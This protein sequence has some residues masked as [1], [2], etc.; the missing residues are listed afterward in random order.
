MADA[1]SGGTF[2]TE[3][4][5]ESRSFCLV[6]VLLLPLATLGSKAVFQGPS[7]AHHAAEFSPNAI[8][9]A[10]TS[11][12]GSRTPSA[13]IACEAPEFLRPP[14]IYNA[15]PEEGAALPTGCSVRVHAQA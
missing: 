7:A 3:R 2:R 4:G 9:C 1:E 8:F 14:Q 11:Y 5:R 15:L 13:V 10:R 12:D 6:A